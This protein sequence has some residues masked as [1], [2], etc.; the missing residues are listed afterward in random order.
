MH[1]SNDP[2]FEHAT[3]EYVIEEALGMSSEESDEEDGKVQKKVIED[4]TLAHIE[5][6][7]K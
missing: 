2:D 3:D 5:S 1:D 4:A 7:I 6:L